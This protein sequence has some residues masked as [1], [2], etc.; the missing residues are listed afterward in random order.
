MKTLRNILFILYGILLYT[1][2]IIFSIS[3]ILAFRG[4]NALIM[5]VH[6]YLLLIELCIGMALLLSLLFLYFGRKS[7]SIANTKFALV[8]K[9]ATILFYIGGWLL[10]IAYDTL[11]ILGGV[12]L[13]IFGIAGPLFA[14]FGIT[15]IG[16]VS[17]ILGEIFILPSSLYS[18]YGL[19]TLRKAGKLHMVVYAILSILNFILV[20]DVIITIVA[21]ILSKK[22]LENEK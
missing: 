11:S 16:L 8:F 3:T 14:T 21:H 10:G 4:K 1:M 2:L 9:I 19:R 22:W 17:V 20:A 18:W 12:F 6:F 5:P 13:L 7:K 15:T